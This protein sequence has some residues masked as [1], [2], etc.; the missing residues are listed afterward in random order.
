MSEGK[1]LTRK[2]TWIDKTISLRTVLKD[3]R[4]LKAFRTLLHIIIWI[5]NILLLHE[6][7]HL[8]LY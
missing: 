5:T 3:P 8:L 6:L 1:P 4:A 7:T 2:A